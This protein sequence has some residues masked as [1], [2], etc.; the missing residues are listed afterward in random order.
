M[1]GSL[2]QLEV[3]VDGVKLL[4]YC[5]YYVEE[6]DCAERAKKGWKN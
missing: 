2:E 5:Y 6:E 3:S 1:S 4:A